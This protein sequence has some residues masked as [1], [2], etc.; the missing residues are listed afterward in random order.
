[1]AIDSSDARVRGRRR[2]LELATTHTASVTSK[3]SGQR[4]LYGTKQLASQ[5]THLL[6]PPV[7]IRLTLFSMRALLG[8]GFAS[9]VS[10]RTVH[11]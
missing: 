3:L 8:R 7:S 9:F 2:F 6:A 5:G 11:V 10:R 4:R 1:M